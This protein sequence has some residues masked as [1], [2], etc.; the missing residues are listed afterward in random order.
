MLGAQPLLERVTLE[1]SHAVQCISKELIWK[2][3]S[4]V[5]AIHER[6]AD[7][8]VIGLYHGGGIKLSSARV[9]L[10][11]SAR[12]SYVRSI[13][14]CPANLRWK[15]L[16]VA[17]RMELNC[18]RIAIARKFLNRAWLEVPEKSKSN[19][20]LECSR[21]EEYLGNTELAKEIL[22]QAQI[23]VRGDWKIFLEAVLLE[24]RQGHLLRA[25]HL[26][27]QA[28][29]VHPGAGRLWSTLIHI[30]HRFECMCALQSDDMNRQGI[31]S[32]EVVLLHALSRCPKSGEIWCE[33]ARNHLNPLL[34]DSFDLSTAQ[35]HL[36]FA[37]QFTP[38]YGDTFFEMLR[39]EMIS[40]ILLPLILKLLCIPLNWFFQRFLS[41]DIECDSYILAEDL[42]F[43]RTTAAVEFGYLYRD[44][45]SAIHGFECMSLDL[46]SLFRFDILRTDALYKR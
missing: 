7:I 42:Y 20:F 25:V 11:S 45:K 21:L 26:A 24:A 28:L 34:S 13:L 37:A 18:G 22:E 39:L 44:V 1:A 31:P 23:E 40:Q 32:K 36:C 16:L 29:S 30:C 12:I 6:A 35:R 10:Y 17:S 9:G 33:G 27:R 5:A 3:H 46:N 8:A 43:L 19:V 38:Q 41:E 15:I 2:V 4:E 14:S